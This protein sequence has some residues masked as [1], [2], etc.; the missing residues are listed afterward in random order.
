MS[1]E[2]CTCYKERNEKN[3]LL[4]RANEIVAPFFFI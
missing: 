2:C 4:S 3:Y 1:E